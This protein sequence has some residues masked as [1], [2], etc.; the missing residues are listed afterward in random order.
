MALHCWKDYR[1]WL[2]E[3]GKW[4]TEEFWQT[5][6]ETCMLEKDHEGDHEWMSD[7]NIFVHFAVRQG[8]L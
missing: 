4:G 6:G 5:E 1:E 2:E 8:E 7:D 3:Q